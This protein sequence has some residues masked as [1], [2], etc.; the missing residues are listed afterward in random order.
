MEHKKYTEDEL[1]QF[2]DDLEERIG[3]ALTLYIWEYSDE[4]SDKTYYKVMICFNDTFAWASACAI[5]FDKHY[6]DIPTLCDAFCEFYN[7]HRVLFAEFNNVPCP[8][9]DPERC[10]YYIKTSEGTRD[11]SG[12]PLE[13]YFETNRE[14]GTRL[15]RIIDEYCGTNQLDSIG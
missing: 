7:E 6:E 5:V 2:S 15:I 10:A 13:T 4:I 11:Y 9:Y 12:D 3:N 14:I 1:E 8:E